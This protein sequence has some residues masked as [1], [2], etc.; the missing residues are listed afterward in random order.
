MAKYIELHN[1][2]NADDR[3]LLNL[4]KIVLVDTDFG[5]TRI[6]CD[7]YGGSIYPKEDY[8]YIAEMLKEE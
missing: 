2:N 5:R 4:D 8:A 6:L 1:N 7:G 3:V